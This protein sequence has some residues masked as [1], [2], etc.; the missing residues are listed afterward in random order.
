MHQQ[1]DDLGCTLTSVLGDLLTSGRLFASLECISVS[2]YCFGGDKREEEQ[3]TRA[4]AFIPAVMRYVCYCCF[5]LSQQTSV[6]CRFCK[7]AAERMCP[8]HCVQIEPSALV[9]CV[10][11]PYLAV[12]QITKDTC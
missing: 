1:I 2:A 10:C 8:R 12:D 3:K 6:N 11:S 4:V 5:L 7:H 9:V